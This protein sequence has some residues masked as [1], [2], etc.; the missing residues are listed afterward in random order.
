MSTVTPRFDTIV[1]EVDGPIARLILNRPEKLNAM[2]DHL[3]EEFGQALDHLAGLKSV[4]AVVIRGAGRAFCVGYDL[5]PEEHEIGEADIRDSIEDRDRLLANIDL[6]TRIWRHP[7]PVIA[8]VHGHCAGGGTQIASFADITLVT[9]ETVIMASPSLLIGGGYLSP[10]W[11][12]LVGPQRAKLMSFDAGR[13]ITGKVA[14]EWGWATL[15]FPEE[16]FDGEVESLVR[17]IARTPGNVL[18]MKKEAINRVTE[19]QG[20]LT[21]A[22]MGVET[23]ALIHQ[24]EEVRE[25]RAWIKQLGL[26]EAIERFTLHGQS[27]R[28]APS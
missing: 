22:R 12:H 7:V 11:V 4:R 18:R 28:T 27:D 19:M 16:K 1:V 21:Y 14:A 5:S 8:A 24:S 6:F 13:R 3:L 2:T 25:V 9:D 10:L 23:D 26:K 17:S 20:F 15:S